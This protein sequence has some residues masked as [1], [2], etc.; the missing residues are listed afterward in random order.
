M[1]YSVGADKSGIMYQITDEDISRLHH[2]L[3]DMYKDINAVCEKYNIR[4]IAAGGTALGA[5]RHKG[6]IPWD[7]DMDLYMF[8]EEYNLFVDIFQKELAK[9]YYF[10]AP[11]LPQGANCFV[12]RIMKKG[13]TILN[14]ID[15]SSPYPHGIYIDINII[16]FAPENILSRRWKS[17]RS[18][19]RIFISYSV[20]L[21]QYKSDILKKY[22][23][24]SEKGYYYRIRMLI[25]KIFSFYSAEKWFEIFDTFCQGKPSKIYTVP[26]GRKK[27]WG[28]CITKDKVD[29]I[30][31]MTFED[32][33][34]NIFNDFDWYLKNL[35][36]NY[37]RIPETKDREH[38]LC[39]K[40]SFTEE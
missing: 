14:M 10:L 8:R 34:I 3:L 40:L 27:Y 33:E 20:Y 13:T 29:P 7:D 22:M 1:A 16:D 18:D 21:H 38:H 35:Y 2:I 15:E 32:T 19:A 28:E 37:M 24:N 4:L 30:K 26:S 23:I 25:G 39:L 9:K 11:G 5:V 12:P 6:F 17:V 36:G 31:R